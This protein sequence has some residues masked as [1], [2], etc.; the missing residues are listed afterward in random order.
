MVWG[1]QC[2]AYIKYY[3]WVTKMKGQLPGYY[4][5]DAPPHFSWQKKRPFLY[6]GQ[7]LVAYV[8]L[9]MCFG[10]VFVFSTAT[11]W[12]GNS[13]VSKVASAFA[14]VSNLICTIGLGSFANMCQPGAM[15]VIFVGL[16]IR[17][18]ISPRLATSVDDVHEVLE[19][20]ADLEI[21]LGNE[22]IPRQESMREVP[23]V[24]G[25]AQ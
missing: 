21:P 1:S 13:S 19:T 5:R 12:N 3:Y 20:L 9:T 8:G 6:S 15:F 22:D 11:W 25:H 7:P 18:Y 10:I 16:K 17:Q 24:N 4:D 2:L 23:R 14:G